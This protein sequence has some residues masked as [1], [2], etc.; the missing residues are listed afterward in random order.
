MILIALQ[1]I[2]GTGANGIP[3]PALA[4]G[5]SLSLAIGSVIAKRMGRDVDLIAVSAWQLIVGS[6]PLL[7]I[8]GLVEHCQWIIVDPRFLGILAFLA[9]AETALPTPL[10]YWLL[11]RDEVGRLS[12]FLFL[13][14]MLGVLIASVVSGERVG[15]LEMVGIGAAVAGIA[16]AA[17][18]SAAARGCA[19]GS[20]SCVLT[21]S[22][23]AGSTT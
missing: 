8:C 7:A 6:L 11:Q 4:L 18:N 20:C 22:R 5:A 13:V 16:V 21:T 19:C 15:I 2:L 17:L 14:P 1:A 23:E 10:W 12:L 9:I 3:G